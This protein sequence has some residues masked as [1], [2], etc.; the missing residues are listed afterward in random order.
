MEYWAKYIA[1][2]AQYVLSFLILAQSEDGISPTSRERNIWALVFLV[3]N[4]V[5]SKNDKMHMLKWE[6]D[7]W[8]IELQ[9]LQVIL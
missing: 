2:P 8:D 4:S 6:N 9:G 5:T 7:H 3:R 1:P